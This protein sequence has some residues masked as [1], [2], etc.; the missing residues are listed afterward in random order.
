MAFP[1]TPLDVQVDLKLNGT[2]TE[3]TSDVYRRAEIE[4]TRG[5]QNESSQADAGSCTM[6]LNNR[7]GKYSPRNPTG[8]YYGLIGRNTP[9]R[10]SVNAGT[11]FLD[12]PDSAD[13][14]AATV[15]H[16]SLDITGDIDVRLE[17]ALDD[18]KPAATTNLI[19]KYTT[20]VGDQRSWYLALT[21]GYLFLVWSTAGTSASTASVLS[22]VRVPFA[23]ETRG[24]VR[25]TLDV[26]NGASGNTATFYTAPTIDGPWTQ[27]GDERITAGTT[28]I[29]NSTTPLEVG[30]L[31]GLAWTGPVGRVY[32]AEVRNGIGGSV[33]ANP[34]WTAQSPGTASFVDGAGR[35]W[36]L[37]GNA[38]ISNRRC[39]FAGEVTSWPIRWDTSGRDIYTTIEAAG[40]LRRLGQGAAPLDSPMRREFGSPAR[41]HIVAYWPCEDGIEATAFASDVEGRPAMVM[42]GEVRPASYSEWLPSQPLPVLGTTGHTTGEVPMYTPA[43]YA[44]IRMFAHVSETPTTAPTV[45]GFTTTGTVTTWHLVVDNSGDLR[46]YGFDSV[47]ATALDT[48]L[49]GF[50][51]IIGKK[52]QLGVELTQD[53]ADIDWKVLVFELQANG[54]TAIN[55]TGTL[56]T[57]TIGRVTEIRIGETEFFGGLAFGHVA[58]SDINT[59]F[60]STGLAMLG[61]EGETASRR[62][63]RIGDENNLPV[64]VTGVSTELL[65]KQ[66][67]A[68]ALTLFRE[69]AASDHGILYEARN[70]TA[71]AY[72]DLGTLYNQTPT[73]LS[74]T[75]DLVPPL[76]PVD[77]DRLTKNYVIVQ[78]AGGSR[79]FASQTTGP[80]SISAPP[81]GVGRYEDSQT[82]SLYTDSQAAEHA[83][84]LMHRGTVDE[85]RYPVVNIKLQAAP[86]IIDA[87]ADLDSGARLQITNTPSKLP[88]G[89]IDLIVQG[90]RETLAQYEWEIVFNCEPASPYTVVTL[91][92]ADLGR[93]DTDG[94]ELAS[95]VNSSATSL[96]V[97]TTAGPMWTTTPGDWP[98]DIR[99]GGEVMTVTAISGSSSPQTFTVTRSVNGVVKSHSAGADVELAITPILA[100]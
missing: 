77:D 19:G 85:L 53:G 87:V 61:N 95:G 91:D 89:D 82:L 12:L 10:V 86:G 41:T 33:V 25:V 54:F 20:A 46:L 70:Q 97:A 94:S 22:T 35:T 42:Q 45:L 67:V 11:A 88:P 23:P 99:V 92:D 62:I 72:R 98:F 68:N 59:G 18:W 64:L 7:S 50:S 48:G 26:N 52:V 38:S 56:T 37:G 36:T 96:S 57:D 15:D 60:E 39:R 21:D 13:D 49:L 81:N 8:P 75:T 34:D 16:A 47:G 93:L 27:L 55:S 29:F 100:L 28:S 40:I 74:Y 51:S 31:S 79:G 43:G 90:Y 63:R 58:L 65:G 5:R 78:R 30:D 6:T 24:A 3:I 32:A 76:E 4:I 1:Q 14:R 44:F 17:A 69:A 73:V 2:W 83:S 9:I 66:P 84:W 80:L 71:V